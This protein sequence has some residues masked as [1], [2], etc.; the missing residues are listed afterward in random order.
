MSE[1]TFKPKKSL[2]YAT[3]RP[4]CLNCRKPQVTC[5]CQELRPFTSPFPV[6]ILQH[7]FEAQNTIATAR[8][9]HLSIK[10]SKIFVDQDFSENTAA[11]RALKDENFIHYMLYPSPDAMDIKDCFE[12]STL[13]GSKPMCFW[14]LDAKWQ[15]VPKML[16]LCSLLNKIQKVK[17][18]PT[19]QSQFIIRKQPSQH[20]LS[21]IE[22]IHHVIDQ[23]FKFIESPCQDH[24]GLTYVFQYLVQQ[25]IKFA[26]ENQN[27]RHI[28]NKAIRQRK[29]EAL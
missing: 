23:Y 6:G 3:Y 25:Q 16:R 21:T 13:P 24:E 27:N 22:S 8:M 1:K 17:F 26:K 7:P 12:Q 18:I 4:L 14:V 15:Q 10:N 2:V 28:R 20:Y 5:F 9:A 29:R 19:T 11:L